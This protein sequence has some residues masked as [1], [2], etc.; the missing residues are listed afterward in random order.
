MTDSFNLSPS[1]Y[2]HSRYKTPSPPSEWE[3]I[4]LQETFEDSFL[5]FFLGLLA[6]FRQK[7]K[8]MVVEG[9]R[10]LQSLS[11]CYAHS[12]DN[13]PSL[14]SAEMVP[15]CSC[16]LKTAFAGSSSALLVEFRRQDSTMLREGEKWLQSLSQLYAHTRNKTTPLS[17]DWEVLFSRNLLKTVFAG[18]V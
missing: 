12:R 17:S 7:N 18:S 8:G 13:I 1:C 16:L 9:D 11:S 15:L 14:L 5:W 2:P 3:G 6:K 10:F 4:F